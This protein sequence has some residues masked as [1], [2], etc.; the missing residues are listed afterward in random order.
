MTDREWQTAL[1]KQIAENEVFVIKNTGTQPVYSDYTVYSPKSKNVYRIAL[2]SKDN[3]RNFCAC[4]DFKTNLLGTCK[5][6]EAVRRQ[7]SKKRGAKKLI[8]EIP[9][10]PY[11]SMYV[12]YLDERKIKLWVGT[13]NRTKLRQWAINFFDKDG[14]LL[15]K[16][17][18]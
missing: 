14:V 15:P 11:S 10:A 17:Y 13:T 16:A 12:S 2:R 6:I 8:D 5:H 7:L 9:E 4:P 18:T 3:S 1:R